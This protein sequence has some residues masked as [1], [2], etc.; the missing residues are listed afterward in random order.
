MNS[1]RNAAKKE[2]EATPYHEFS[3]SR[4]SRSICS[5]CDCTGLIPAL[6]ASEAELEAY[7]EMYQFCQHS[8][9]SPEES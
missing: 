7:E 2:P 5:S 9:R 8:I 6:P 1:E 4:F 3:D